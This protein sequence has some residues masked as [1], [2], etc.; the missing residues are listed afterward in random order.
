MLTSIQTLSVEISRGKG[1]RNAGMV[2]FLS[3]FVSILSIACPGSWALL[4]SPL[5]ASEY[6]LALQHQCPRLFLAAFIASGPT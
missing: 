3:H 6:G 5:P 1:S 2:V 4:P